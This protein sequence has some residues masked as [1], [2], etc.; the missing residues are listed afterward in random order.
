MKNKR[1]FSSWLILGFCLVLSSNFI[2]GC[3][4]TTYKP[5]S[6]EQADQ[7]LQKK[8]LPSIEVKT[9]RLPESVTTTY[10]PKQVSESL[11][12]VESFPLYAAQPSNDPNQVYLE[13]F[14]SAEKAN[15]EKPDERWLVDVA[16]AFNRQQLFTSS[17]QLIQVGIRNIP[18]G[19]AQR[20]IASKTTQPQGFSPSHELWLEMLKPENI[21]PTLI[22]PNLLPSNAGFVVHNSFKQE[23]SPN[24]DLTFDR[25]LEAILSGKVNIGYT[26]PYTSSTG[27][28]LLY[29]LFWRG[30]GHH[31]Y[32]KPLTVTDLQSP[33][34]K[35]V[36][37][38]FQKQVLVTALITPDLKE[39]FVRDPQKLPVFAIDYLSYATLKQLPD[40]AQTT[41]VPFGVPQSSPLAGFEW[42]TPI[43]QEALKIFAE[44]AT[45]EAMQKLAPTHS[46]EVAEYLQRQDLPPVPNGEILQ[47]VQ[48]Y[49]KREK[50]AGRTVY[51]MSVIDTSGSM[52]GEPLRAVQAGL[53]LAAQE[54]NPDNYVGLVTYENQPKIHV[55]LAPF[56]FSQHQKLLAAIDH[57][58]AD[59]NTAMYDGVMV[60]LSELMKQKKA[61]PNGLFYLLLLTDGQTNSGF[62]FDQIKE[63]INQ[64]GVR[65]YPIA[66]GEV[67]EIELN[68][69]A[70]LRE[71]TVKVGTVENVQSLLKGLFQTNL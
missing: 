7:L 50:D 21:N 14:S 28:N 35:S 4:D 54:I 31:Q 59:G 62:E 58:Q 23:I 45:S 37:N 69:I 22:E 13:I 6:F 33:Q 38:Q 44:F 43:E 47:Q 68:A 57:L 49:W 30:A 24:Q 29:T 53:K 25:V 41:Y 36:F 19:M 17:G 67:N 32:G 66:Y 39:I 2:S 42:N 52:D 65:V 51:L 8:V 71:S 61:D 63:I 10:I 20:L 70:Q 12:K 40:F 26:N 16:E 1:R 60:A 64:S 55:P 46:I 3:I 48:S 15:A 27:L 56:D 5:Q 34:V 18:S 9:V 11:P